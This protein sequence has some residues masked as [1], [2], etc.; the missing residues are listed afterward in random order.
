MVPIK[1]FH[2]K[3]T[4]CDTHSARDTQEDNPKVNSDIANEYP[5]PLYGLDSSV[6]YFV[7]SDC[8]EQFG[9]LGQFHLIHIF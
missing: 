7:A 8:A 3:I 1:T 9:H 2:L 5:T 6:E 4:F